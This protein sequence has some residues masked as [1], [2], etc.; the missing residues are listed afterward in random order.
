MDGYFLW[1]SA[2]KPARSRPS[3][4]LPRRPL[5]M[6]LLCLMCLRSPFLGIRGLAREAPE[7][8]VVI[9]QL[10]FGALDVDDEGVFHN[11]ILFTAVFD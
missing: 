11:L 1:F 6:C 4:R 5:G 8:I 9:L 2:S 7:S 3:P 10:V